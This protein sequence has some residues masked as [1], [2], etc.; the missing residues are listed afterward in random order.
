[1]HPPLSR[2]HP[3]CQEDIQKLNVCHSNW[4]KFLGECN[5][6]KASLDA[7]LKEEK[8]ALLRDL[9]KNWA[10]VRQ[11]E[12]DAIADALGRKDS[13]QD[14]LAKDPEYLA[15]KKRSESESQNAYQ[16]NSTGGHF[17]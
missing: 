11:R 6:I 17:T 1:M 2:P 4:R 9:N 8:K 13:F 10:Q 12:E 16:K 14:Y 3:D 5:D 15:A 7:C